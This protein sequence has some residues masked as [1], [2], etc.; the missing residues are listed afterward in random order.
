LGYDPTHLLTVALQFPDGTHT[1][2]DERKRFY[3]EVRQRV[4]GIAGVRSA[5]IYPFGFPPEADFFRRLELFDQPAARA[6][7]VATNPVSREF[8]ATL[9]IPVLQGSVWSE[10]DTGRSAHVAVVNEA[11]AHRYWPGGDAIGR[12]IRLPDFTAF[13]SWMLAYPGS[14]DWLQVLG[15]VGNTP[16][17]GLAQPVAPAVYLPYSLVLG[18][19][20]N[21][22]VRTEGNPMSFAKAIRE[23]VRRADAGQPVNEIRTA[24]EVL[25]D[26]GW[27]AERFAAGLFAMFSGLALVLAAIGLYSVIS[28]VVAQRRPELA[29][30]I[31]LG[32]PRRAVL[33]GVIWGGTRAVLAG[34]AA[35]VTMCV[36]MN[37]VFAHWTQ[38]NIDDPPV[39]VCVSCVFLF[40]S[41]VASFG[42]A[43]RAC[44]VDPISALRH[45]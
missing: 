9:K 34:L 27:A 45:G 43:W 25:A 44:T 4:A 22:A 40:T 15:V 2:L 32:S 18:D 21:L 28:V 20:F 16:N 30:R 8:F 23:A 24:E 3:A 11:F 1:E 19:S 14:N 5:A 17:D 31:A 29:I 10:Q 33:L 26:E 42:P 38:G 39:I 35:G 41:T 37:G 13:T 36:L 6:L 7:G 12:R